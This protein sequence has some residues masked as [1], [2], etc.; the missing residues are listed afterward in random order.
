MTWQLIGLGKRWRGSEDSK[1]FRM[2]QGSSL[3]TMEKTQPSTKAEQAGEEACVRH[4]AGLRV[5]ESQVKV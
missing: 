5:T 4:R 3:H 1:V 2:T